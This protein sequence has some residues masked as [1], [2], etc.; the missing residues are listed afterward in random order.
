MARTSCQNPA[1]C[2]A[3]GRGGPC[4]QCD[5]AAIA[6][7][8]VLLRERIRANQEEGRPPY[9]VRSPQPHKPARRAM[10]ISRMGSDTD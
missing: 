4:R 5:A 2:L 9:A 6:Q 7:R 8:A 1:N 10:E 3:A